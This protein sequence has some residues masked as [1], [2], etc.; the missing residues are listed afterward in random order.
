[1]IDKI[2]KVNKIEL[3]YKTRQILNNLKFN[4]AETEDASF[5]DLCKSPTLLL[6]VA[7]ISFCWMVNMFVYFGLSII[8]VSIGGNKYTNFIYTTWI[9]IPGYILSYYMG[10]RFGRKYTL[11]VS[12]IATGI[13]CTLAGFISSSHIINLSLFLIGKFGITISFTVLYVY[14]TELFPTSMRHRLMGLC[15]TVALL[16]SVVAPQVPLLMRIMPSLPALLFG[17]P[18]IISGLLISF[19]PETLNIPL[20]N[21]LNEALSIGDKKSEVK[22]KN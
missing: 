18:S 21:T 7:N 2:S 8:S 6:R 9:E 4:N 1:M 16:G 3:S 22:C 13:S 19:L 17:I 5:I 20:P 11:I 15:S 10:G 12:L 14:G